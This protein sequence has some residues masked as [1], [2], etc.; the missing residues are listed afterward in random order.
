MPHSL[1]QIPFFQR[2]LAT[3]QADPDKV[4]LIDGRTG[5]SRSYRQL[6]LDVVSLADSLL[7][8][9]K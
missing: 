9:S 7:Q 3:A 2:A 1:P 5:E 4:A 6:L 8:G